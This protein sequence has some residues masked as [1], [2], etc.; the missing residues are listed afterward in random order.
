ME[1]DLGAWRQQ[2]DCII[3]AIEIVRYLALSIP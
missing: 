2:L 3:K 1:G